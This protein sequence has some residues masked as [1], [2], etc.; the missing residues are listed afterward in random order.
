M[1]IYRITLHGRTDGVWKWKCEQYN[2]YGQCEAR[3]P[4]TYEKQNVIWNGHYYTTIW[5]ILSYSSNVYWYAHNDRHRGRP[6]IIWHRQA[7]PGDN[8]IERFCQMHGL[9][10]YSKKKLTRVPTTIQ[11]AAIRGFRP[12]NPRDVDKMFSS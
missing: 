3:Q 6:A 12:R 10:D 2:T 11:D 1:G 4:I 8:R 7:L 5:E 9:G